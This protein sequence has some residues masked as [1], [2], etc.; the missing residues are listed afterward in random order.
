[1]ALGV[2]IR[3]TVNG[4]P[5]LLCFQQ[6]LPCLDLLLSCTL[7]HPFLSFFLFL[8]FSFLLSFQLLSQIIIACDEMVSGSSTIYLLRIQHHDAQV[9]DGKYT[10]SQVGGTH[11]APFLVEIAIIEILQNA[12]GKSLKVHLSYTA[13]SQ[14]KAVV[15][16]RLEKTN[17]A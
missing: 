1:M 4:S 15:W 12:Q 17:E 6:Q 9:N 2:T 14:S 10:Q 16:V 8:F 11:E 3:N 13:D 7:V 5:K